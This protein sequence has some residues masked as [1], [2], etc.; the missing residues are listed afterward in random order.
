MNDRSLRVGLLSWLGPVLVLLLALDALACYLTALHFANLV[1]D[2]WLIDDTRS[3]AS[4]VRTENGETQFDVP[5]VAL[6]I[7]QFDEVDR[8]FFKIVSDHRGVIGGDGDLPSAGGSRCRSTASGCRAQPY[9]ANGCASCRCASRL[10]KPTTPLRSP[11]P[12]R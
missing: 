7:F 12:R 3:L 9:A 4:A 6:Q 10:H 1:Y 8:T 2:R 5:R 11:L